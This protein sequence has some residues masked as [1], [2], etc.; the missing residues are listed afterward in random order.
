MLHC[1]DCGAYFD[2]DDAGTMTEQVGECWGAPAYTSCAVCPDCG[3]DQL[4]EA[5]RCPV[6]GEWIPESQHE[7]EDCQ[8][9]VNEEYYRI[10]EKLQLKNP[11]ADRDALLE[12]MGDIFEIFYDKYF[13]KGMEEETWK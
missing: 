1:E 3:S 12:S 2:E 4:E 7:C 6:C 13:C 5:K 9:E 10:F 8:E 11:R